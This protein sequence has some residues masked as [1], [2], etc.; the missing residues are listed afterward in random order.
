MTPGFTRIVNRMG[1]V[2][3]E[4]R[5]I[6]TRQ[7]A[8]PPGTTCHPRPP[9]CLLFC[10]ISAIVQ[11]SVEDVYNLSHCIRSFELKLIVHLVVLVLHVVYDL[12]FHLVVDMPYR[13]HRKDP[14]ENTQAVTHRLQSCIA[15]PLAKN[16]GDKAP[17]LPRAL[18]LRAWLECVPR[19]R[20]VRVPLWFRQ[21]A[22]LLSRNLARSPGQA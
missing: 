1:T 14:Y 5:K 21:S 12:S 3:A 11:R 13:T 10:F 17:R 6:H 20:G 9:A 15:E 4:Y 2:A 8:R 18:E 22:I 16:R 19:R 7:N